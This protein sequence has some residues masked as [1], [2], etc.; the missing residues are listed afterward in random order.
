MGHLSPHGPRPSTHQYTPEISPAEMSP[1]IPQCT[2]LFPLTPD[3]F[4]SCIHRASRVQCCPYHALDPCPQ[5]GGMPVWRRLGTGAY[6]LAGAKPPGQS[7][8]SHT[9]HRF[10]REPQETERHTRHVC[11]VSAALFLVSF[12]LSW[13]RERVMALDDNGVP[14]PTTDHTPGLHRRFAICIQRYP[15][16]QW[17][18]YAVVPSPQ[19]GGMPFW[20]QAVIG[21]CWGGRRDAP[22]ADLLSSIRSRCQCRATRCRDVHSGRREAVPVLLSR[23]NHRIHTRCVPGSCGSFFGLRWARVA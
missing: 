14:V 23:K 16:I 18:L 11:P 20:W 12:R 5:A 22:T 8:S 19:A 17:C 21:A 9:S 6:W 10:H 15:R 4:A 2:M 3:P 1:R 13:P 7:C